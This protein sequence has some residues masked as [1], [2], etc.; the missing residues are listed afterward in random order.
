MRVGRCLI[1]GGGAHARPAQQL[2]GERGR[3]FAG[4]LRSLRDREL[5]STGS[6]RERALLDFATAGGSV[7]VR[8][9]W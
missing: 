9:L 6:L 1:V 4:A 8:L 3:R 7:N 2:P 5:D